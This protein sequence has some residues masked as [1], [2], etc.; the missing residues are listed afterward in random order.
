M[1]PE[2]GQFRGAGGE[3]R[4]FLRREPREEREEKQTLRTTPVAF[5]VMSLLLVNRPGWNL[6]WIK[7]GIIAVRQGD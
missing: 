5:L 7:L 2:G 4:Y 6:I 1:V 3:I